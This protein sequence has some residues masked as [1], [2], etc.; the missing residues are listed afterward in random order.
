M[1]AGLSKEISDPTQLIQDSVQIIRQ[2]ALVTFRHYNHATTEDEIS[3]ICQQIILRLIEDQYRRLRLFDSRK[4][5]FR[6]WLKYVARHHISNYL[7]QKKTLSLDDLPLDSVSYPANQE[8]LIILRDRNERLEAILGKLR[9]RD[10]QIIRLLCLEGRPAIDVARIMRMT[11]G[12]VYWH[13]NRIMKRLR[14]DS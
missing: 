7:R 1:P 10:Q 5:S 8:D 12:S 11:V 3:D 14:D 2:T 13:K 6:T 4:S 9:T